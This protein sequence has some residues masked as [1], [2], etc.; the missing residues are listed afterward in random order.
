M[1]FHNFKGH[2]MQDKIVCNN[3]NRLVLQFH[4]TGR[5]NLR[6]KHCYREAGEAEPL[7][8]LQVF[9]ILEQFKSYVRNTM[10]R[11]IFIAKDMLT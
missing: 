2:A 3:Y 11:I 10:S 6:C 4:I 9:D 5:C 1:Q 7:T 8:Y